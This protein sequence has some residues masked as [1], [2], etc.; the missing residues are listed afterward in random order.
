MSAATTPRNANANTNE[1]HVADLAGDLRKIHRVLGGLR[2]AMLAGRAESVLIDLGSNA[3]DP[4]LLGA[5]GR[6][7]ARNLGDI[8]TR[9]RA[10]AYVIPGLWARMQWRMV[11]ALERPPVRTTVV[12]TRDEA[13]TWLARVAA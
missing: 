4:A 13:T 6:W 5:L 10:A 9:M 2:D 1:I 12:R 7:S 8:R 3:L 11:L